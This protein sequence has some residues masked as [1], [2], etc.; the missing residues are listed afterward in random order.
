LTSTVTI[1]HARML[2][3]V[4]FLVRAL[5]LALLI[6]GLSGGVANFLLMPG[7]WPW[8]MPA[9]AHRF[10]AAAAAAYVVGSTITLTR[11]R[12]NAHELLLATVIIY[13]IPLVA[14]IL[15]QPE[16][17]D[18][19]RPIAWAFIIIVTSALIISIV[20]AWL[21]RDHAQAEVVHP[22]SPALRAFFLIL[23]GL[24][25]IVGLLVFVVPAHAGFVW[26][27]ATL[28]AWK[29]LDSRLVAAMLLTIA[30]GMFL[31]RWRNDREMADVLLPML[32]TYAAVAGIGV[33]LHA[34]VTPAF[35]VPDLIYMLIFAV[36]LGASVLLRRAP[37]E[38]RS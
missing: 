6:G 12:W 4:P 20:Y 26:P 38:P 2:R 29:A 30:G 32:W 15:M 33:A 31:V 14:A 27:W 36:V 19:R 24:A 16:V 11:A 17:I 18:W 8:E 21:N 22:L 7:Y 25:A 23:G 9:L 28:K 34:V 37:Q 5:T 3:G 13:G 10:L 1:L 35:V